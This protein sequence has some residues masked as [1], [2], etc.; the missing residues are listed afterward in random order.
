M[1]IILLDEM[2]QHIMDGGVTGCLKESPP[3]PQRVYKA[4][5]DIQKH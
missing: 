4:M 1:Y 5:C 2:Y 3:S